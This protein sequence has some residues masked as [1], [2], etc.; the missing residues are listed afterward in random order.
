[1]AVRLGTQ[2]WINPGPHAAAADMVAETGRATGA[3]IASL[4]AG[5]G[6]GMLNFSAKQEREVRRQDLLNQQGIE[7]SRADRMEAD[8][9]V[10]SQV[11]LQA[12]LLSAD[13]VGLRMA[14]ELYQ[15]DPSPE[16]EM[17]V[18]QAKGKYEMS[19]NGL[20]TL[21]SK[22]GGSQ[23]AAGGASG[24]QMG[25]NGW[26][27][28]QSPS[29]KAARGEPTGDPDVYWNERD[30]LESDAAQSAVGVPDGGLRDPYPG[31][32]DY[33]KK[34]PHVSGMATEDDRVILNPFSDLSP[35]ERDAVV[36]NEQFRIKMRR[37]GARPDFALTPQQREK[38]RGYGSEQDIRETIAARIY[39][40]DPSTGDP[41]PAQIAWVKNNS[42]ESAPS[43]SSA[44]MM[45][46]DPAVDAAAMASQTE[47][48][49]ELAIKTAG[50]PRA[51]VR[52]RRAAEASVPALSL[53]AGRAKA[54]AE[55]EKG[56]RDLAQKAA[57]AQAKDAA[58]LPGLNAD[59]RAQ[60]WTGPD[61][62]SKDGAVKWLERQKQVGVATDK[63]TKINDPNRAEDKT[64]AT[65]RD[66]ERSKAANARQNRAIEFKTYWNKRKEEIAATY[67]D[68]ASAAQATQQAIENQR[69]RMQA[70]ERDYERLR[71]QYDDGKLPADDVS[72]YGGP[73]VPSAYERYE[74][75][76]ENFF[77]M[78]EDDGVPAA[79]PAASPAPTADPMSK[80]E[81]EYNAL[82]DAEKT[83]EAAARIA[84]KY[85]IK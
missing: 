41:T 45:T 69:A 43:S 53:A 68:R 50:S 18:K 65:N 73:G 67:K 63:E 17:L 20:A 25:P 78:T 36:K 83:P 21:A 57:E 76:R 79:A 24:V 6:Q 19:R 22:F 4:G 34:N 81:A 48:M 32:L 5:I 55:S 62:Q 3:G 38:F 66:L 26:P 39:S 31:E 51:S 84:A 40:G 71:K 47:A 75:E 58:D 8:H 27:V 33:F 82:P 42:G 1:M 28:G 61:F 2:N 72:F 29:E 70:A 14:V 80:A 13:E 56:N 9:K 77:A 74:T 15:A 10:K 60:G 16:N 46:G 85:G 7:N 30:Y 35:Q 11:A 54:L 49:L 59:A 37:G 23:Q 12:S 44:P 64:F 52:D